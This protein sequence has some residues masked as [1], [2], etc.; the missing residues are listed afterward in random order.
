MKKLMLLAALLFAGVALAAHHG[1]G[2]GKAGA[3]GGD[4]VVV[5]EFFSYMCPHCYRFQPGLE[6][7]LERHGDNIEFK[8]TPVIFRDTW[9]PLAQAYYTA[10]SLGVVEKTHDALFRAIHEDNRRFNDADALAD[11]FAEHGVDRKTFI[12]TYNGFE[13][14][15]KMRQGMQLARENKITSTPTLIVDGENM[16]LEQAARHVEQKTQ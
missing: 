15:M 9:R 11:F 7:F 8:R 10:E 3:N 2:E 4:K 6:A 5:H 12:D 1:D 14:D 16:N 13:V